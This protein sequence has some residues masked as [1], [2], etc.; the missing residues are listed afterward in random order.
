[1]LQVCRCGIM[2]L[3]LFVGS[4]G[5]GGIVAFFKKIFPILMIFMREITSLS[6]LF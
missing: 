4:N 3:E 1:M 2:S 6:P 5:N